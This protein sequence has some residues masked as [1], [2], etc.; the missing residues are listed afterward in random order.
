MRD[1]VSLYDQI[2]HAGRAVS[3]ELNADVVVYCAPVLP[4][5]D[6][7]LTGKIRSMSR[8]QNVLL[9]LSTTGGIADSAYRIARCLQAKYAKFTVFIDNI[10]KSAGTMIALGANEVIMSDGA[11][12]GPLDVQLQKPDELAERISGLAPIQSLQTLSSEVFSSFEDCFLKLR[13]RSGLQITTR[14]AA[15]IAAKLT[16]GLFAPIF[17]QIDPLALGENQR[18]MSVAEHYGQRLSRIGQNLQREALN[19]LIAD[20]PS[21]DFV[22]ERTEAKELFRNIR[23]PSEAESCLAELV[24]PMAWSILLNDREPI[25]EVIPVDSDS[26]IGDD[27]THAAEGGERKNDPNVTTELLSP[28]AARHS[29]SAIGANAQ[30]VHPSEDGQ[31]EDIAASPSKEPEAST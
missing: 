17:S 29:E 21:H 5:N 11:E 15:E 1:D 14:T 13:F 6:R 12:I 31:G 8:N 24:A 28:E 18:A 4:A 27:G 23:S 3:R 20:Y 30:I 2:M 22:I 26:Q 7:E 9:L 19:R 10:C 16:V 25:I